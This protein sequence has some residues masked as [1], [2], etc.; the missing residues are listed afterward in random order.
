M[1]YQM[2]EN[3]NKRVLVRQSTSLSNVR[4]LISLTQKIL[5]KYNVPLF[6]FSSKLHNGHTNSV[7]GFYL[8]RDNKN[9]LTY[10]DN[11]FT[12]KLWDYDG[13]IQHSYYDPVS[14][15]YSANISSNCKFIVTGNSKGIIRLWESGEKLIQSFECEGEYIMYL[16]FIEND[17]KIYSMSAPIDESL[18]NM[19][20]HTCRI[21]NIS[22]ACLYKY[23][24][25]A[26]NVCYS[27]YSK[28]FI[29]GNSKYTQIFGFDGIKV[30]TLNG[31][32]FSQKL[33]LNKEIKI[34]VTTENDK[35]FIWGNT[36]NLIRELHFEGFKIIKVCISPDGNKLLIATSDNLIRLISAEGKI[37]LTYTEHKEPI[38]AIEFSNDSQTI[39][40]SDNN[41]IEFWDLSGEKKNYILRG[42]N[43]VSFSESGEKVVI[44]SGTYLI[45]DNTTRESLS[46]W[47][48]SKLIC[49]VKSCFPIN[50]SCYSEFDPEDNYGSLFIRD[51]R[52]NEVLHY[53]IPY[54]ITF[55]R[56]SKSGRYLVTNNQKSITTFIL[57][58]IKDSLLNTI[59][60]LKKNIPIT[61]DNIEHNQRIHY[62]PGGYIKSWNLDENDI[63]KT[64]SFDDIFKLLN[65]TSR[66]ES[67]IISPNEKYIISLDHQK[68]IL[69]S[70][71]GDLIT[72]FPIDLPC[73]PERAVNWGAFSSDDSL[74]IL[75]G[76]C[77]NL[78]GKKLF[79]FDYDC[80]LDYIDDD[81]GLK[82]CFSPD[83][84]LIFTGSDDQLC[85]LWDRK[86][87]CLSVFH[88]HGNI[89][90]SVCFSPDGK[91]V[92]SASN[93]GIVI[94]WDLKGNIIQKLEDHKENISSIY[95]SQDNKYLIAFGGG[96]T[97]WERGNAKDG[98]L[99]KSN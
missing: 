40:S 63:K 81:A 83:N 48:F 3:K 55:A 1:K 11:D 5:S 52:G 71:G 4:N 14:K 93:D 82:G 2:D 75:G 96:I 32:I 92:F 28:S 70:I 95:C 17:S 87:N 90:K 42:A 76:S 50:D 94:V 79:D 21:W 46:Y 68:V 9:I 19:G 36:G 51:F 44:N 91:S 78:D 29:V 22:G 85:K 99:R 23:S 26:P 37:I 86:G 25:F 98:I 72:E 64:F 12:A 57:W 80:L 74:I 18:E 30:A 24:F 66:I 89:I 53:E 67:C 34:I 49:K 45:T 16:T 27:E 20:S 60:T 47:D 54:K 6:S 10:S 84:N 97:V 7:S 88:G 56:I 61:Y 39:L 13:N 41:K 62:N 65:P 43:N 33:Y 35:A 77:W 38:T 69:W 31:S 15:I 59:E 58:D 8:S 73:N